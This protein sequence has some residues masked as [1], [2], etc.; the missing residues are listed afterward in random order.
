MSDARRAEVRRLR[1]AAPRDW[2][3]RGSILLLAGTTLSVWL[4]SRVSLVS[5]DREGVPIGLSEAVTDTFSPRRMD[6]VQRFLG[7]LSPR[8]T[9]ADGSVVGWFVRLMTE[10]GLD[11]MATTLAVA[12]FAIVLAA[13]FA[14]PVLWFGSRSLA[15]PEPLVQGGRQ[16]RV[17]SRWRW[18]SQV[19]GVR[20]L[21]VFLRALPEYVLA[22]V[23]VVLGPG[24]WP[25][26]LA[27]AIHNFGILGRL[28]SEVVENTDRDAA[29]NARAAGASRAQIATLVIF[30]QTLSRMLLYFF[31]RWESCIR[32]SVV[33]G[34]LGVATLGYYIQT[35]A[36]ARLR[37]DEMMLYLMLGAVL[38]IAGDLVSAL[39]RRWVRNA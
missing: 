26:V 38:V 17:L 7:R 9:E 37:Y 2:V 11:A 5:F 23:L 19:A 10:K 13:L 1:R 31:Y 35:D 20:G 18:R 32:E 24:A 12:V 33:L 22:F 30:P 4:F 39:V 8:V 15:R 16:P 25:A 34:M 27:L 29:T 14:L 6:N 28:G 3:V 21:F 36:R